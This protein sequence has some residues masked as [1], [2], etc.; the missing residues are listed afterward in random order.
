[1]AAAAPLIP[2][3]LRNDPDHMEAL[4]AQ[5]K[6]AGLRPA[7]QTN[8]CASC[9]KKNQNSGKKK[10]KGSAT[11]K[12]LTCAGCSSVSYC[13]KE[14]QKRDW[15]QGGHKEVCKQLQYLH[16][17]AREDVEIDPSELREIFPSASDTALRVLINDPVFQH[18][19]SGPNKGPMMA[20]KYEPIDPEFS[21]V[22]FSDVRE[23]LNKRQLPSG[24]QQLAAHF[25]AAVLVFA[26]GLASVGKSTAR[27]RMA[28]RQD[29]SIR[30][31]KQPLHIIVLEVTGGYIEDICAGQQSDASDC[32]MV[33]LHFDALKSYLAECN[34]E[35]AGEG[36]RARAEAGVQNILQSL[37]NV[38]QPDGTV[39]PYVNCVQTLGG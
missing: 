37:M 24:R 18:K 32:F 22:L 1:M 6:E 3:K 9:G 10:K 31:H 17:Q 15:K 23:R 36:I 25:G 26:A 8:L 39:R 20:F 21:T 14:C 12:S 30:R 2:P 4:M 19:G 38:D 5:F 16:A 13:S 7:S 35:Y 29:K 28:R 34:V 33:Y 11:K 27:K